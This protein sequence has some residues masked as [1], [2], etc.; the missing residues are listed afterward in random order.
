[1]QLPPYVCECVAAYAPRPHTPEADIC[2][3]PVTLLPAVSLLLFQTYIIFIWIFSHSLVTLVMTEDIIGVFLGV[4]IMLVCGSW[5]KT[6]GMSYDRCLSLN[7]KNKTWKSKSDMFF[8]MFMQHKLRQT[9]MG[10]GH[11]GESERKT[12][13][14]CRGTFT[15]EEWRNPTCSFFPSIIVNTPTIHLPLRVRGE[16]H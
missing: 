3:R 11:S 16:L 1:M 8:C 9:R 7:G 14:L 6:E 13:H 2:V 10:G 15:V 12:K 4:C 5:S